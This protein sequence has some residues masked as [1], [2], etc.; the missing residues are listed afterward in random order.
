MHSLETPRLLLREMCY[1]DAPGIL[2]LDSN[3][4]VLRYVPN[5]QIATL[6]EARAIIAY[7]RVQYERNGLGR[8]AVVRQDTQEFIGWCGVKL[9]DDSEVNGRTRYHDIGYRLLPACWG[10]GFA[11]EAA[12]ATLHYALHVLKLPEIN[13]TV[14]QDNVASRRIL[15]KIGLQRQEPFTEPDGSRWYWYSLRNEL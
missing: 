9:V 15:E 2:A 14:M 8:W 10:Q 1:E 6:E 4:A 12:S 7:I 5:R 13:A 11:S 3:P